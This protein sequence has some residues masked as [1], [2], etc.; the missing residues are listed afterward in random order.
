MKDGICLMLGLPIDIL[1]KCTNFIYE[2]EFEFES[3]RL[4]INCD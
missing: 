2:F 3:E 1:S 4:L